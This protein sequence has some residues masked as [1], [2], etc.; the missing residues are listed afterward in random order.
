M[1]VMPGCSLTEP[2]R[3]TQPAATFGSPLRCTSS[4]RI[5]LSRTTCCTGTFCAAAIC[6]HR[7]RATRLKEILFIC[8]SLILIKNRCGG[9]CLEEKVRRQ[10]Y[11]P[12]IELSNGRHCEVVAQLKKGW[13]KS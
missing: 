2:T 12:E 11:Q 5:P 1:P 7:S 13:R 4:S 9:N 10:S 3:A 8:C 6:A